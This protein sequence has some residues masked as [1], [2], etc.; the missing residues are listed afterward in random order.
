MKRVLSLIVLLLLVLSLG[1]S[2][3]NEA[4][5]SG[6]SAG[7]TWYAGFASEEIPLPENTEEPLYIAVYRQGVEITGVLDLPRANA[8]WLDVGGSGILLIGIDC[9]GLGSDTVA[10]IREELS[11]FCRETACDVVHVYATH[12]HAGIDTLGLWGPIA[13]DGKNDDYME[14]LVATAVSAAKAAYT[15][16][17]S[18]RLLYSASIPEDLLYDSRRPA[19]YDPTLYQ[20]RFASDDPSQNGVRLLFYAAHA[21]SLRGSNT[22]LSRDFPG[23]VSDLVG[24]ATGD[25]VMFL[26]G[27]IGGLIMTKELVGDP[28]DAEENLRLTGEILAD[29]VLAS[30]EETE[31]PPVLAY[32]SQSVEIPLDNTLF[33]CYRFLGNLGNPI[34]NGGGETGY[35]LISEVGALQ[36]GD[37]TLALIPGELFPELAYGDGRAEEDPE[38]LSFV[39]ARYGVGK[40]LIVGLCNDEL[41]YIVPPSDYRINPDAPY[42]EGIE[43][44]TGENHYEETNS[45]GIKTAEI[46]LSSLEHLLECLSNLEK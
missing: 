2:C 32:A 13:V 23:V 24:N 43:D 29:S 37:V 30:A 10:R 36:L 17:S 33:L 18:G 38:A 4:I 41:G 16:R 6:F 7:E 15:D 44:E 8:V 25:G 42:L 14:N 27:A 19:S 9:V 28:F 26:P 22:L 11:D 3:G 21:E 20:I 46:I 35:S 40:L 39:A 12:T 45:A 31:I 34:A 1:C 5:V